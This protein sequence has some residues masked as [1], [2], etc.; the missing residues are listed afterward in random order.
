MI[1]NPWIFYVV[2]LC[3]GFKT[4]MILIGIFSFCVGTAMCF[5]EYGTSKKIRNWRSWL[6]ASVIIA[7]LCTLIPNLDTLLLMTAAKE[8]EYQQLNF[9][10]DAI[11]WA[12]DYAVTFF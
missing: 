11:R 2:H 12:M 6:Y 7:V 8:V 9:T 1:I 3:T 4:I 10:V 5:L